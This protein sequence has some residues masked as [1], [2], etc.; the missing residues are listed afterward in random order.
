LSLYLLQF[1]IFKSAAKSVL[2]EKLEQLRTIDA[3][4]KY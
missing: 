3:I 2:D 1:K 4:R